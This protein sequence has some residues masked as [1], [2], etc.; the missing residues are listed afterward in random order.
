[1]EW[2]G[3]FTLA[4]IAFV[5]VVMVRS[6]IPADIVV[7]GGTVLLGLV[8]IIT[9]E[10]VV[11][12][13]ANKSVLTIGALF[14]VA[15]AM[16]ET[17]ALD[18]IG[19]RMLGRARTECGALLRLAPQVAGLSAFLN[20]TAVVSMVIPIINDWC[21]KHRIAPSRM[22]LPL[23]YLAIMG[24]MCTLIGTSRNLIVSELMVESAA[25]P[26]LVGQPAESLSG[27]F[28][29]FE[30]AWIGVPSL[31]VGVVYLT[32]IGRRWLPDRGDLLETLGESA[33]EYVVE[34]RVE[35]HC[36]HV[37]K[38][39]AEAGLRRLPGLFLIEILRGERVIAP[40][41][42][43]ELIEAGDQLTFTGVVSTIVDLE[44]TP[45]LV[46][47]AD[48][49]YETAEYIRRHRRYCE[50]VISRTSPLVGQN[51]REA[52][53]RARHN[54][55]IVAVHRGGRRLVGRIGD[56][57][58]RAGDTLLLQAGAHFVD[59][60]R[61]NPD[62]FLVSSVE[63]G[64]PVRHE[65]AWL[66][67][68]LLGLL[69]VLM[70][71]P[72]VHVVLAAFTIA[73]LMIASRCISPADARRAVQLDVLLVIA[74][75]FGL[76]RAL[77]ASGAASVIGHLLVATTASLGPHAAL[78]AVYAVTVIFGIL[79]TSNATAVLLFPI[80]LAAAQQLGVDPR[81]F[82][83]A[84]TMSASASFASPVAYQTNMLVAG[85]GGYRFADFLRLGLPLNLI[86]GVLAVWLIP[87]I[88]PLSFGD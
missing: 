59:A 62:F 6:L 43:D 12:G 42:P 30:L 74:A 68:V 10:E 35:P 39:V 86:L 11:S 64:R 82:A 1:M 36:P 80:A 17:G 73:G 56:F 87:L 71:L 51:I 15:A 50:A 76:G 31:L 32:T 24:G 8:G 34:L 69:I 81:P 38:Q 2:Q 5:F 79:V 3:W 72:Q 25:D 7:W 53:F 88:W 61:N 22:L 28:S 78:A 45:G 55:A 19:A 52:N 83:V 9:P 21:R 70:V 41:A 16:R 20:N 63:G 27:G 47:I 57:R 44:R 14:V 75:S 13:F 26:T 18:R 49:T 23:A 77:E 66:A 60:N 46:P 48:D 85:P 4:I 84:V 54:A 65:R 40:V 67:F 37:G 33:R 29:M 58:L